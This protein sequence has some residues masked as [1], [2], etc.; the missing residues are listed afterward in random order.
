[1]ALTIFTKHGSCTDS[2]AR[3]HDVNLQG[4]KKVFHYI[5]V[6]GEKLCGTRFNNIKPF[7]FCEIDIRC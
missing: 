3:N 2:S 6:S 1:M 5:M 4:Q 7:S